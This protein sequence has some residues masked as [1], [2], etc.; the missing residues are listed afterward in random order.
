MSDRQ[1]KL[2]FISDRLSKLPWDGRRWK[3][4]WQD[5]EFDDEFAELHIIYLYRNHAGYRESSTVKESSYEYLLKDG[6]PKQDAKLLAGVNWAVC[7]AEARYLLDQGLDVP[8]A[9]LK[10]GFEAHLEPN[11]K[12]NT[13]KDD[14]RG[15]FFYRAVRI[16]QIITESDSQRYW[17]RLVA[18]VYN[19]MELPGELVT[20]ETVRSAYKKFRKY[21]SG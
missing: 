12:P 1:R 14:A 3:Q 11:K 19:K 5:R 21:E 7:E 16:L 13:L 2:P 17:S 8:P 18:K 6:V 10:W 20:P 15:L 9:L 4:K